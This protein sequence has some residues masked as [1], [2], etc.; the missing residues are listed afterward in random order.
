MDEPLEAAARRELREETGLDVPGLEQL[1]A[2]GD[3]G[4]DPR[5]RTISVVYW[6]CLARAVPAVGG[7]DAGAAGW[8]PVTALPPL[9]FDHGVIILEALKRLRSSGHDYR[10]D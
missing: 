5:G 3:P 9:A 1:G 6:T 2:F 10:A 7:D 4:R 8:F